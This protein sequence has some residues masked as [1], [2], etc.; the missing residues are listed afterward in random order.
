MSK[1]PRIRLPSLLWLVGIAVVLVL[2]GLGLAVWVPYVQ[3]Q[4]LV[5]DVEAM[6]GQVVVETCLPGWL[7]DLVAEWEFEERTW[8]FQTRVT[9]VSLASCHID[10]AWL[11]RLENLRSIDDL[12]LSHT[13][14]DDAALRHLSGL[15]GVIMLDLSHTRISDEGLKELSGLPELE[16]LNLGH[17]AVTGSGLAAMGASTRLTH[18]KVHSSSFG[19]AGMAE[20]HRFPLFLIDL[21]ETQV[22]DAGIEHLSRCPGI[23]HLFLAKNRI[24]DRC[25][26]ALGSLPLL[27]TLSL[28]DTALTDAGM[29]QLTRAKNLTHLRLAGTRVTGRGLNSLPPLGT[30]DLSRAPV[31]DAGLRQ[32]PSCATLGLDNTRISD[33]GMWFL[34]TSTKRSPIN[35]SLQSTKITDRGLKFLAVMPH[36]HQACIYRTAGTAAGIKD[37]MTLRVDLGCPVRLLFS[38]E[39]EPLAVFDQD[40]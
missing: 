39:E 25:L 12:D 27:S 29:A 26:K 10:E 18:L 22:T 24:T 14:L 30:L 11:R 13:N 8:M 28:A 4:R 20:L 17:T 38:E 37:L 31:D 36:L 21:K 7:S 33:E 35:I 16:N 32:L 1:F 3:T 2:T 6:G 23:I 15:G 34:A 9:G 19:D 40:Y 5:R